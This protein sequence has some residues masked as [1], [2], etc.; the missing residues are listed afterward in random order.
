MTAH[1]ESRPNPTDLPGRHTGIWSG[2][3]PLAPPVMV[4]AGA[5][6][7][8]WHLRRGCSRH[9]T[10]VSAPILASGGTPHSVRAALSAIASSM[11]TFIGLVFSVVVLVVQF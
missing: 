9:S 1:T 2:P 10:G 8:R 5:L 3:L 7:L 4:A 11:I 6:C